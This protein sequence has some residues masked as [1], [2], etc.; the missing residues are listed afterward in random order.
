MKVR[1]T[2]QNGGNRSVFRN[3]F[4]PLECWN[5]HCFFHLEDGMLHIDKY[6]SRRY[7]DT[8]IRVQD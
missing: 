3:L 5:I 7:S 4:E 8:L 6:V 2:K 1:K